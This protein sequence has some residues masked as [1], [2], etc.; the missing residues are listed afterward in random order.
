M[1]DR[2]AI[3]LAAG[4]GTRM[5]SELPKVLFPVLG[6][7]MVHWVLDA[8]E[9]VGIRKT[10]VVVGYRGA[11]VREELA[12]RRNLAFVTQDKQLG[13]GH[14]VKCCDDELAK[15]KGPV[16]VLAGDS[17]L[18]QSTSLASL[19]TDFEK[20][21][22]SCLMGT[23]VKDNPEGLGRIIRDVEG[24]FVDIVEHKD[25]SLA[26]RQ[27]REVNMSTY[28]FDAPR[29]RWALG[30]LKDNNVQKEFYLTDCPRIL[31]S[32]GDRVEAKAVLQA[33]EALSIN[34]I[35]ELAMVEER[36]RDLGYPCKN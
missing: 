2:T 3:V 7:A 31:K 14:A 18:V 15:V 1:S 5:N 13:T 28:L 12:G 30:Q 25:A 21:K 33:C 22:P 23:L 29:L 6:R 10:I 26:Q 4:K 34:T 8:L 19:L 9:A 11:H 36:M 35:S 32:A 17:P 27:M 20:D 16:F 24:Q